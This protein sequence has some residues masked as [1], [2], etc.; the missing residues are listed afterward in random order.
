MKTITKT[1]DE[2]PSSLSESH[3]LILSLQ[4]ELAAEKVKYVLNFPR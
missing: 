3:K 2:L 4:Q 1:I